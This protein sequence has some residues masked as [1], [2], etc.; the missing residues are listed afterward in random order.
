MTPGARVGSGQV[1]SGR[2]RLESHLASGGMA[3]VWSAT[4]QVLG[5][6]VAVKILHAHLADDDE[7]RARFHAEAVAAARLV[8]PSIVAIYDT[9]DDDGTEAIVMELVRGRTLR[10][11]LDERARLEPVEVVHIGAEVAAALTCAH[12]SGIIHRDMKPANILLSDDGRVLVTDFG[13][14]KVLDEPDLTRTTQ[15]LGTVKYLAPEQVEGSKVDARTDV[16]ALG[17][18]LYESLCGEPPFRAESAAA[19]ALARL[20]RPPSP[21]S[22]LVAGVPADLDAAIVRAL[23]RD[24]DDRFASSDDMRTALQ[25]T[26]L[27]QWGDATIITSTTEL[28]LVG[29][30]VVGAQPTPVEP[31]VGPGAPPSP[32]GSG[33]RPPARRR[34]PGAAVVVTLVVVAALVLAALLVASTKAGRDLFSSTPTTAPTP[35]PARLLPVAS[36]RSYDPQGTGA[37]GENGALAALAIDGQPGTAWRTET[38]TTRRFGNLKTGVGLV[39]DLGADQ[40]VAGITITSPTRGWA[41][42][43]YVSGSTPAELAGWGPP[44][45][46]AQDI[47]GDAQLDLGST[48]GR[49]VLVWI[50]D[51]GDGPT[52]RVE[53]SDLVITS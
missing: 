8:H 12:R 50:T 46:A 3:E 52:N 28:G 20:Q 10:A 47:Q 21:P 1:L 44:V 6:P 26:R 27:D 41:V 45:A 38:Y 42:E 30:P 22:D 24:P 19:L 11:F 34:R 2:Y 13:I 48:S 9:C 5:R 43:I 35:D 53:M 4:D 32:P 37:A 29:P 14:A 7:L 51:L 25:A 17:A 40:N 18:V 16:Y 31:V 33:T 36:A 23:A 15:L 49:S 39:V